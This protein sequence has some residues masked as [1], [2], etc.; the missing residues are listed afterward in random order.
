MNKFRWIYVVVTISLINVYCF[1]SEIRENINYILIL[2]KQ[3][4]LDELKE[5][6]VSFGVIGPIISICI[7]ILQCMIAPLPLSIIVF[8]NSYVYGW[9]VGSIISCIGTLIGSCISFFISRIYGRPIA[10][11]FVSSRILDLCDRVFNKYGKKIVYA[12][13]LLPFISFDGFS[14]AAGLTK[15]SFK[16]FFWATAI[17]QIPIIVTLSLLGSNIGSSDKFIKGII[18]CSIATFI[19]M[20]ISYIIYRKKYNGASVKNI[21]KQ[22]YHYYKVQAKGLFNK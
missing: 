20:I 11:K 13:R 1:N 22:K 18:Y 15:M 16:Y 5:Y 2:L 9:Q 12:S 7:L 21:A 3:F 4:K 6:I 17:G 10:E 19:A 8:A 14:Y